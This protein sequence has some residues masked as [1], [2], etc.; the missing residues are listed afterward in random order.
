MNNPASIGASSRTMASSIQYLW[1]EPPRPAE[2]REVAPGVY[3]LRMPL[4]FALDHINLWLLEDGEGWTIV[5]TGIGREEVKTLWRELLHDP[6]GGRAVR[7]IVVTHF[8]PDHFGLAGWLQEVTHAPLWMTRTEWLTGSFLHSDAEARAV[9]QQ[10]EFF[11]RHGLAEERLAAL[12]RRGNRYRALVS[13]P[14]GSYRRLVH[15]AALAAGGSEWQV[16][17]GEGHAPE[18]ACLYRK[19]Q[20]VL[21]AG[22]QILPKITPNVSLPAA[23]P[24][25]D[26]LARFLDSLERFDALPED[27]LVLPSHGY[28]FRGLHC[29]LAQFRAHHAARLEELEASCRE[30]RSA[31]DLLPVL[32]RREL[33]THQLMFAMG[34]SLSHLRHLEA[35]GRLER[36]I[37][38]DGVVRY[39][40]CGR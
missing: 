29:R 2:V 26:P 24:D 12:H 6:M 19:E 10:V 32:F 25:A 5:D 9:T 39:R 27:T 8:H 11:R 23:E 7:R 37:G 38:G 36:E 16:I 30:P 40:R 28:P 1:T 4:P 21:I 22:D 3:W 31:A 17:V 15:G 34:E 35:A 18:H 20:A 14:P 33:D 13:A